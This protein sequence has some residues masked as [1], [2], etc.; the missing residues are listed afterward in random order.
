MSKRSV[1]KNYAYNMVYQILIMIIPL[2][3]APYLSRVLGPEKT[4]IYSYTVSIVT[5]F[6]LFGSLGISI[7]G[8]R[9]IAYVR[10][11]KRKRSKLFWEI[12]LLRSITVVLS[13]LVFFF[14][15]VI[16]GEY[17]F[18]FAILMLDLIA[19][20]FDI[21]WFFQ[22]LEDFKVTV[23]CNGIVRL[24]SAV[25]IFMFVKTADDLWIYIL[26]YSLSVLIGNISL[27][28][29]VPKLI[30][31][32]KVK[33]RDMKRHLKPVIALFIPQ[34]ASQ[35]YVVLDKVMLGAMVAD[36]AELG[37]Y[38]QG[39]KI[40]KLMITV[41][42]AVST[43]LFPRIAS[44]YAKNNKEKIQSYM[45]KSF[46]FVYLLALPMI[47]GVLV[48][49][50]LFVPLFYGDG[51]ERTAVVMQ[52]ISPIILI[53][54][55]GSITGG[56]YLIPTKRQGQL[57][58]SYLAGATINVALNSILISKIGAVGAAIATVFAELFV[59]GTQLFFIRKEFKIKEILCSAW[60][61]LLAAV[62]MYGVCL[63][64]KQVVNTGVLSIIAIIMAGVVSYAAVLLL[65][66]EELI[67]EVFRIIKKKLKKS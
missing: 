38:E 63:L 41:I 10:D 20:I 67:Q 9:E 21:S 4:G 13:A 11:D 15:F 6:I 12:I 51:F 26:I 2:V 30:N 32:T 47:F 57:T 62:V 33:I 53:I 18:Y 7:Y 36:K 28:A 64:T 54:G 46:R 16:N 37:F 42:T 44:Y 19:T 58:A 50:D 61:Y 49:A 52:V 43:V 27:W 39:E 35:I 48:I 1:I 25:A 31:K 45:L 23:T 60:K 55:F 56:Q 65:L 24:L 29:C 5:Y 66:K 40:I 14:T 34:I 3:T 59:S 8:Q 17:Q 22:G